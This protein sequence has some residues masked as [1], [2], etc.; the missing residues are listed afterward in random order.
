MKNI[1][2]MWYDAMAAL[3]LAGIL[4][5]RRELFIVLFIMGFTALYALALNLWTVFSFHFSQELDANSA[6]KGGQ[7]TLKVAI[8][9]DMLYPFSLM[10]ISV[11]TAVFSERLLFD[12]SLMPHGSISY[13]IPLVCPYRGVFRVGIENIEVN[14]SFGLVKTV[15]PMSVLPYYRPRELKIYPLLNELPSLPARR[16]DIK[17]GG[18]RIFADDGESFAGLRK[19]RPG[20]PLKRLH[21]VATARRRE[22]TVKTYDLPLEASVSIVIDTAIPMQSEGHFCLADLA[23]ECAAAIAYYSLKT[24]HSVTLAGGGAVQRCDTLKGFPRMRNWLAVLEFGVSGSDAGETVRLD[25]KSGESTLYYITAQ[26][27]ERTEAVLCGFSRE[28]HAIKTLVLTLEGKKAAVLANT[29]LSARG[30]SYVYIA[31]GD[32]IAIALSEALETV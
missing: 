17:G 12:F 19:Y 27:G 6:V 1:K 32:D 11:K 5:G 29:A 8:H 21:H 15:F 23:C 13:D 3:F 20:D 26:P 4:T 18:M 2:I 28:I 22:L 7:T 24:G 31:L 14:D 30:I 16:L 10:R 9:N 25:A